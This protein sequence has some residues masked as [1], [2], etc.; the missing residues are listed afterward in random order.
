MFASFSSASPVCLPFRTFFSDQSSIGS[1]HLL[2]STP[3]SEIPFFPLDNQVWRMHIWKKS[4]DTQYH[5][6]SPRFLKGFSKDFRVD[7]GFLQWRSG[8]T[9]W[10]G[11]DVSLPNTQ[12]L[13]KKWERE[14]RLRRETGG[15]S[16][17]EASFCECVPLPCVAWYTWRSPLTK[18]TALT[19]RGS[20]AKGRLQSGI[21]IVDTHP[22]AI[23]LERELNILQRITRSQMT[24]MGE[25]PFLRSTLRTSW[26]TRTI[27]KGGCFR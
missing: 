27:A 18:R 15:L 13:R 14:I 17:A 6:Q 24:S 8:N 2:C 20:I 23:A 5:V 11:G 12:Q 4:K 1:I 26:P 19:A 21:R 7:K 10:E 25:T 3:M 22:S 16:G 9:L